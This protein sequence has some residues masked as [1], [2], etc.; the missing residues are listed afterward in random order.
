MWGRVVV[1]PQFTAIQLM[2]KVHDHPGSVGVRGS[3]P[4]SSTLVTSLVRALCIPGFTR[5][6]GFDVYL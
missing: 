2:H 3:S 1:S 6:S 5:F 4:L